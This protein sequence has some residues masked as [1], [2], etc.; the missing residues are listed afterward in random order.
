VSR[1]QKT[2]LTYDALDLNSNMLAHGLQKRGVK[3]GDRV[4]VSLGNNIEYV[5][6]RHRVLQVCFDRIDLSL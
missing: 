3:R 6:V 2:T 1:H 4:A 5:T